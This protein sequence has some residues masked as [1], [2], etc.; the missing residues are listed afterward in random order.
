METVQKIADGLYSV[1]MW[2]YD[3]VDANMTLVVTVLVIVTVLGM[4]RRRR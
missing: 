3:F 4:F 1:S 2:L